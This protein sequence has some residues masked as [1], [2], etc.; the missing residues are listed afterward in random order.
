MIEQNISDSDHAL[1]KAQ[2]LTGL[3]LDVHS[4][5]AMCRDPRAEDLAR[6]MRDVLVGAVEIV[7]R[8]AGIIANTMGTGSCACLKIQKPHLHQHAR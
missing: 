2:F 3:I 6:F 5:S 7:E 8:R 4:F 1:R